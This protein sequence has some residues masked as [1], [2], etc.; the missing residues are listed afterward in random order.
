MHFSQEKQ[1]QRK[2]LIDTTIEMLQEEG[3]QSI[4][5]RRVAQESGMS[6]QMIYTLFG[7]KEGLMAALYHASFERLSTHM[8]T[9]L[10][11]R[12]SVAYL[13][14]LTQAMRQFAHAQPMF[15]EMMFGRSLPHF[16][17]PMADSMR[18]SSPYQLL[19]QTL[20][21]IPPT[22][23]PRETHADALWM[24]IH[25]A[26]GMELAGFFTDEEQ[27]SSRFGAMIDGLL[28]GFN[29]PTSKAKQAETMDGLGLFNP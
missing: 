24:A 21:T 15:Y 3:A 20:Q 5:L 19:L 14:A 7:G 25:G 8:N 13:R 2:Q 16:T 11:D 23:A 4:S 10:Y 22:Q 29:N 27:A 26:L 9:V 28:A 17:P 18:Q 1:R 6:T 12:D